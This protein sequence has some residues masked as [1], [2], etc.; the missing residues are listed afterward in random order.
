MAS[1]VFSTLCAIGDVQKE[2]GALANLGGAALEKELRSLSGE[3][4]MSGS[5]KL[6]LLDRLLLRLRAAG[7]RVLLFSQWTQTLDVLE[8]YCNFRFGRKNEVYLRL[9]GQTNR[10]ARELD[11]R[12]F[13]APGSTVFLYLVSTKAGGQGI[14]LATADT[15]VLYDSCW[16][17]QVDLQ[18][19]DRAHR[20]GQ[21]KQVRV[22]R[23]VTE[24]SVEERIVARAEQKMLLD[25]L[26]VKKQSEEVERHLAQNLREAGGTVHLPDVEITEDGDVAATEQSEL[27]TGLSMR[28]LLGMLAFGAKEIFKS[29]GAAG[30]EQRMMA[31]DLDRRVAKLLGDV[32]EGVAPAMHP[33]SHAGAE[34]YDATRTSSGAGPAEGTIDETSGSGLQIEGHRTIFDDAEAMIAVEKGPKAGSAAQAEISVGAEAA[35]EDGMTEQDGMTK[36]VVTPAQDRTMEDAAKAKDAVMTTQE[37]MAKEVVTPAQDHAME[38]AAGANDVGVATEAGAANL[39]GVVA[40]TPVQARGGVESTSQALKTTGR[41]STWLGGGG[42]DPREL[43]AMGK[44]AQ[45]MSHVSRP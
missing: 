45:H 31:A 20:I 18:A 26:V 7:S 23:L 36:E 33:A 32:E 19:Q 21:T 9:D 43:A 41:P 22:F 27:G 25:A 42:Q 16:N 13:N 24:S 4:L 15:V 30:S 40:Q 11:V 39:A 1:T 10:I 35:K 38:D 5:G 12:T 14:N 6:A 34:Q 29:D 3:G 2:L 8:E 37:G 28:E 44:L 17:P